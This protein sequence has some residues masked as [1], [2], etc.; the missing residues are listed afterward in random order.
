MSKISSSLTP[1]Q[2]SNAEIGADR[3]VAIIS[4]DA[5]E[6]RSNRPPA[7]G[8]IDH[9]QHLTAPSARH[10]HGETTG[11]DSL[12]SSKT[13][14]TRRAQAR[15]R[16][17]SQ[18]HFGS[19]SPARPM[20]VHL[21]LAPDMYRRA[22][23]GFLHASETDR[24]RTQPLG[25]AGRASHEGAHL[26][27]SSRSGGETAAVPGTCAMPEADDAVLRRLQDVDALLNGAGAG[28][29]S[30]DTRSR[31]FAGTVGRSRHRLARSESRLTRTAPGSA[32][33]PR[34]PIL[35]QRARLLFGHDLREILS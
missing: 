19:E 4:P 20:A 13:C 23:C 1:T 8:A 30:P 27:L 31:C 16:S 28:R 5:P 11:K 18:Q 25:V 2:K 21:L 15:R 17:S 33:S 34:P 26:R 29:I 24:T 3:V 35:L 10:Q 12:T 14:W 32:V 7:V 22:G 6:A 9:A